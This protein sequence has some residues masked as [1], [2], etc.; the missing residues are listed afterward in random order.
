[1]AATNELI[2]TPLDCS[3][4][5]R[6]GYYGNWETKSPS[7]MIGELEVYL[8]GAHNVTSEWFGC[9]ICFKSSR[10]MAIKCIAVLK[11]VHK[12]G[13]VDSKEDVVINTHTDG[14]S[15]AEFNTNFKAMAFLY[16]TPYADWS[17]RCTLQHL[18]VLC[19]C[20]DCK[21]ELGILLFKNVTE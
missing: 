5:I 12:D 4:R 20:A 16:D 3:I 6:F 11:F 1:M 18:S 13:E 19:M 10:P 17:I 15:P 9:E 7:M 21:Q 14:Y 8:Q 2:L